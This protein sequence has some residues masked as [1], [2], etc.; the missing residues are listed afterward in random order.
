MKT[1][2]HWLRNVI[3]LVLMLAASGLAVALCPRRTR[4]P[5][6]GRKSNWKR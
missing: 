4:S 1:M 5:I 2:N 3:L 6:K